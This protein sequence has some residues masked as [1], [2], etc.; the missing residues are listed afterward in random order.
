MGLI[1]LFFFST[2]SSLSLQYLL[3]FY[4]ILVFRLGPFGFFFFIYISY[5]T[6]PFP[7]FL[8]AY[9]PFFPS[10]ETVPFFP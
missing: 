8:L 6:I 4:L 9:L 1:N 5:H 7:S 10:F 2:H 3:F